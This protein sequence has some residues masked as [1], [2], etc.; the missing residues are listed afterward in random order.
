[1]WQ[2]ADNAKLQHN[3]QTGSTRRRG[4]A[5]AEVTNFMKQLTVA[6]LT[7]KLPAFYRTEASFPCSQEP[8]TVPYPEPYASSPRLPTLFP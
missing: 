6:Q 1:M 4:D 7:K 3:V 5:S 8:A 2:I